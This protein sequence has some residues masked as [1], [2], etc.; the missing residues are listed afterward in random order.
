MRKITNSS[1][2]FVFAIGIWT[3]LILLLVGVVVAVILSLIW[4]LLGLVG[5]FIILI[6]LYKIVFEK[7]LTLKSPGMIML[8]IG[9]ILMGLSSFGMEILVI[10]FSQLPG[11]EIFEALNALV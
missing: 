7:N 4:G 5:L 3:L 2:G 11:G 8:F 10:D 9:I 1:E 6:A